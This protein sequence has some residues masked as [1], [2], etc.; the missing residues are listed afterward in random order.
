M[1]QY[2]DIC[3]LDGSV[4]LEIIE[5]VHHGGLSVKAFLKVWFIAAN[6]VT[7]VA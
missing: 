2:P 1:Q 5:D 4:D 6:L 3:L 7:I